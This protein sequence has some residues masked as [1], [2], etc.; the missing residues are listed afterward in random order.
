MGDGDKIFTNIANYIKNHIHEQGDSSV[1]DLMPLHVAGDEEID[2]VCKDHGVLFVL[3]D[4][5]FSLLKTPKGKVTDKLLKQ[6]ENW[7]S[8]I[9][10]E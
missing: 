5:I 4:A 3:L 10:T 8:F 7:L 1:L 2:I 6:L 9:L